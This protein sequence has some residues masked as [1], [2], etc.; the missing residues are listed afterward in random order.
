[1]LAA[2]ASDAAAPQFNYSR[3]AVG[4]VVLLISQ[5][6]SMLRRAWRVHQIA[7]SAS[8]TRTG[9]RWHSAGTAAAA[10]DDEVVIVSGLPRGN[11]PRSLAYKLKELLGLRSTPT[12]L[13]R[14]ASREALLLTHSDADARTVRRVCAAA[15]G[16]AAARQPR[17]SRRPLELGLGPS[18]Q[19]SLRSAAAAASLMGDPVDERPWGAHVMRP[20]ADSS[21]APGPPREQP[22]PPATTEA[23]ATAERVLRRGGTDPKGLTVALGGFDDHFEEGVYLCAGCH[24]PLY[25]SSMK[26]SCGC[27]WP[28][29]FI[30]TICITS[31]P[32]HKHMPAVEGWLAQTMRLKCVIRIV[33]Q[34]PHR[35]SS[36]AS[37][38]LCLC[39]CVHALHASACARFRGS[40]HV[41]VHVGVLGL[42]GRFDVR[43]ARWRPR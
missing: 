36:S 17:P 31:T 32:Y 29:R 34:V 8:A 25:A 33:S 20:T 28:V 38:C 14:P 12:V 35:V 13:Q 41:H 16:R 15:T 43:A 5:L 37:V 42:C 6:R 3:R 2:S 30:I 22:P 23:S 10:A 40:F 7:R 19:L 9:R 24:S 26:F 1:V 4:L 11:P 39:V 21:L 27:G 18:I